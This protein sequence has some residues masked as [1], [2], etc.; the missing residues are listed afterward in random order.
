MDA[1]TLRKLFFQARVMEGWRQGRG[2]EFLIELPP[3]PSEYVG[4][5]YADEPV[6]PKRVR[7]IFRFL[8][9]EVGDKVFAAVECGEVCV[10]PPFLVP[11]R[12]RENIPYFP[13]ELA[14]TPFR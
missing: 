6:L 13:E 10:I 12:L 3:T 7:L 8:A 1:A 2:N 9:F 14:C 11:D 5:L 4:W